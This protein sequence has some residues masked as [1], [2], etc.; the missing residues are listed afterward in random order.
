MT[1][2]I[3][4]HAGAGWSIRPIV[5]VFAAVALAC[6]LA[7]P[8]VAVT[9]PTRL[10]EPSVSPTSG[11]PQTVIR[12]EVT[13]RNR[14]GSPPDAVDVV[15]GGSSHPMS[16]TSASTNWKSGVRFAFST[17]LSVGTHDVVFKAV[18]R[19]RFRDEATGES[20]TIAIPPTPPPTPKPSATPKATPTPA[21]TA[22]PKPSPSATPKP[23]PSATPKP[24]PTA[25]PA[26]TSTAPS[27]TAPSTPGSSPDVG[28][29]P[30]PGSNPP[31]TTPA[32]GAS[33]APAD[34]TASL[35]PSPT[36]ATDPPV[37]PPAAGGASGN[38]D[39]SGNGG[40]P[41]DPGD[42]GS[43]WGDLSGSLQAL[44]LAPSPWSMPLVPTMVT[45]AGGV[46]LMMGF[47]FFGKRRRDGEPPEPD[48]VL[49]AAAA[50][51]TG[52]VATGALVPE[53]LVAPPDL[54][55]SMPR[56]RRPSLM[57]ARK[58]DPL[59]NAMPSAPPL[60]FEH[61]LVGALDGLE[62]RIIRYTAV[63]LLDSPDELRGAEIGF[64][65]QGDEVQLLER[66]G[67]YWRVLTPDGRQGWLHR[68]TL[69]ET[70]GPG[71]SASEP[72]ASVDGDVLIAFMTARGRA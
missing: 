45:T 16:P 21:P 19:E 49:S 30:G 20:V 32:P 35:S 23:S 38:G 4:Q 59:R 12:F 66:T 64:V 18:D 55:L 57:Q 27:T 54:E 46:T 22:T 60:S 6:L 43:T 25:T 72:D 53:V 11:T 47:L 65:D 26:P 56:W 58:A 7:L 1:S 10:L 2:T 13:Y 67:T 29:Q 14:E 44:G 52:E 62:R 9:G 24:N 17:T 37:T 68:M 5:A 41:A 51:G 50:R 48:E 61:G 63:R 39:G 31:G 8:A 3:R 40:S 42:P 36:A 71:Q 69:G 34:P 28:G 15:V 70:V 33:G